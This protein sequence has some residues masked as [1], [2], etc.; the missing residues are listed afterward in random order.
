MWLSRAFLPILGRRHDGLT[1]KLGS[2]H[3]K[4]R[5]YLHFLTCLPSLPQFCVKALCTFT[6]LAHL[7]GTT[8]RS[9]CRRNHRRNC[10]SGRRE[11]PTTE[12]GRLRLLIS[13]HQRMLPP[14]EMFRA[15]SPQKRTL[16][17]LHL[18][19]LWYSYSKHRKPTS[20][21]HSLP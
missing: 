21:C 5:G 13:W 15:S 7:Q 3:T 20:P 6:P 14:C 17:P 1:T 19:R 9:T 2:S 10:Q 11:I 8:A 12:P 4:E 18:A 16:L